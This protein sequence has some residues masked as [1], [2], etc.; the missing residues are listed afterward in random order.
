MFPKLGPKRLLNEQNRLERRNVALAEDVMKPPPHPLP[1]HSKRFVN[2]LTIGS[3]KH[4]SAR[5]TRLQLHPQ[6]LRL[7]QLLQVLQKGL[8]LFG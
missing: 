3:F 4:H 7:H 5:P 8:V 2:L 6:I 1:G